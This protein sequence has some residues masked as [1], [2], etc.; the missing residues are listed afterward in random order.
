MITGDVKKIDLSTSS[1]ER[2][3]TNRCLYVDKT[4]FIEHF[5]NEGSSVQLTARQ[6]RLGKSLNMDMLHC[7]LTDKADYRHLFKGLYIETS[8]LWDKANSAPV[9][10]FDFKQLLPDNYAESIYYMVCDY[11]DTYCGGTVLSR[12]VRSYLDSE[13]YT[14]ASGLLYLTESVYRATG[15]RSYIL[16]DEYDKLLTDSYR[17]EKYE[18]IQDFETAFLSAGLKGNRYIEKALL[19]GVM[20]ISHES[21]LSGLNNV[22][23]FDVYSDSVYTDD[24]GLTDEEV[25]ELSQLADLNIG[26]LKEW[27]NGIKINGHAIY[28]TYSVMS[29]IDSKA[30]SCFWGMS[31]TMGMVAGLLNDE[32]ELAI[33]KL[34]NGERVEAVVDEAFYSFLVQAGY[35]ALDEKLPEKGTVLLS[36]PNKELLVVWKDF[37]LTNI[38]SGVVKVRTLFDN[39]ENIDVFAK[40]LEYFLSDRLSYH[41]FMLGILSAYDDLRCKHPLSNRESG[42]GR[43]DIFVEKPE[44]NFIFEF[45]ACDGP[46]DLDEKAGEALAQIDD[47]RYGADVGSSKRLVKIGIAF[48]GKSCRVKAV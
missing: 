11:I 13:K 9:F 44:C 2:M 8:P 20:R 31:G 35:L 39:V 45:K 41:V 42:D 1:F 37:I 47:K 33:A 7:F 16:I 48:F 36:I 14:D 15:K 23:T 43:Y 12:A 21:M 28:N 22:V 18:E 27:Y 10:Y 6:R 4:R 17:S 19:T 25:L 26:D 32:R 34:L 46:D 5:L 24:Y 3:I 29:H 38:F 30:L 40:D